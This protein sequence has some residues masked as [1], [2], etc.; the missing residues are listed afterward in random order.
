[1]KTTLA[2]LAFLSLGTSQIC[3]ANST[4][5]AGSAGRWPILGDF[6]DTSSSVRAAQY[7]LKAKGFNVVVDGRFGSQ[8]E[9]QV[10]KYQL[11]KH[12]N[13]TVDFALVDAQTWESLIPDLKRGSKGWAVR[14][15]QSLLRAKGYKVAVDG[16]FGGQTEKAV[17]QFQEQRDI[18][19]GVI[20][21]GVVEHFTWCELVGGDCYKGGGG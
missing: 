8:T 4:V 2:L 7:L 16:R 15:A 10:W 18:L 14:A 9:E 1:M 11:S 13:T 12:F 3:H 5:F 20:V 6:D 17:R 19:H 21:L